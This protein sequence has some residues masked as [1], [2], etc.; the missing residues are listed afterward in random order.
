MADDQHGTGIALEVIL[1]PFHG[2]KIQVVGGLV[3]NQ[4]IRLFQQQLCQT[5]ARQLT[6]RKHSDILRPG[7]LRKPHTGQ[8]LFDVDI[9]IVAISGIN[10]VLQGIVLFQQRGILRAGGHSALQDL[11]LGHGIQHMGKAGAH[12]AVDI[13]RRVELC[14]LFQIAQ[15]HTMGHTELSLVVRI[16]AGQDLQQGRFACAVLAHDADAVLPFDTGRDIMQDD[17]LAK[18]LAQL[19]QMYQH[20]SFSNLSHRPHSITAGGGDSSGPHWPVPPAPSPAGKALPGC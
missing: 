19:F 9:H 7:I 17:L 10:D 16:L 15:R 8:H 6:A 18:A 13:Q 2:G 14:I 12:L 3:Q 20:C 1:Q 11:H 4:D 5:K